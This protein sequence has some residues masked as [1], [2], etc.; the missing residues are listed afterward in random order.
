SNARDN[1]RLSFGESAALK[2][3]ASCRNFLLPELAA[4]PGA[5]RP[6][7]SATVASRLNFSHSLHTGRERVTRPSASAQRQTPPAFNPTV[8]ASSGT[9]SSIV[10]VNGPPPRLLALSTVWQRSSRQTIG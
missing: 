4:A 8:P 1:V 7:C 3:G 2:N 6:I 5:F 10:E 9:T